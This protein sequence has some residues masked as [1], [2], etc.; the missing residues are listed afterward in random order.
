MIIDRV[1]PFLSLVKKKTGKHN[2]FSVQ[3]NLKISNFVRESIE[4]EYLPVSAVYMGD[5]IQYNITCN[6]VLFVLLTGYD[7]YL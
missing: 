2:F 5:V 7:L 4:H 3:F 6:Y 1:K